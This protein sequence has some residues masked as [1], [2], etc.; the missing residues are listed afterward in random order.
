MFSFSKQS[1]DNGIWLLEHLLWIVRFLTILCLHFTSH[2]FPHE[3]AIIT[4]FS[5]IILFYCWF[6]HSFYF[7]H[8]L[9]WLS[10]TAGWIK[11]LVSKSVPNCISSSAIHSCLSISLPSIMSNLPLNNDLFYMFSTNSTRHTLYKPLCSGAPN[12][13]GGS[14]LCPSPPSLPESHH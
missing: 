8:C 3:I 2:P 4:C 13:S 9:F 12:T 7:F 14:A 5:S 10:T 1:W 11:V 6:V